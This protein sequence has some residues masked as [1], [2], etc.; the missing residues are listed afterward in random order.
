MVAFIIK[1]LIHLDFSDK[2]NP[3]RSKEHVRQ[4]YHH[5]VHYYVIISHNTWVPMNGH[6]EL[7]IGML[8]ASWVW[9]TKILLRRQIFLRHLRADLDLIMNAERFD[10]IDRIDR[11]FDYECNHDYRQEY[12]AGCPLITNLQL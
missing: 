12:I 2:I 5:Q 11:I 1:N 10:Q 3:V 8:H 6:L 7:A 4:I 9:L